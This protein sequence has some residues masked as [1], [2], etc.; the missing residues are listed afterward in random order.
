MI[1]SKQIISLL[2]QWAASRY[3][4][5]YYKNPSSS[6]YLEMEKEARSAGGHLK[7]I[8]FVADNRTKI[9]YV[10][11]ANLTI[12]DDFKE[13]LNLPPFDSKDIISGLANISGGRAIFSELSSVNSQVAKSSIWAWVDRYI[14][15]CSKKGFY[16]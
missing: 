8:R 7:T 11:D 6:D 12:H 5:N 9:V 1:S 13:V 3:S 15:D 14:V 16:N 4:I 2:E 10:A